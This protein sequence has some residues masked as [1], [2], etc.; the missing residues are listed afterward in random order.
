MRRRGRQQER[1]VHTRAGH[2]LADVRPQRPAAAAAAVQRPAAA[3]AAAA[4][5]AS[6]TATHNTRRGRT[7][8]GWRGAVSGTGTGARHTGRGL[9]ALCMCVVEMM[10]SCCGRARS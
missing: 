5:G 2:A 7:G 3:A 8:T 6:H 9:C 1:R 4:A 10:I